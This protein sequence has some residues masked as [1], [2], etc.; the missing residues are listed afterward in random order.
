[1]PSVRADYQYGPYH[2]TKQLCYEA[3]F[4]NVEPEEENRLTEIVEKYYFEAEDKIELAMFRIGKLLVNGSVENLEEARTWGND[5]IQK[6]IKELEERDKE[7][8]AKKFE[9]LAQNSLQNQKNML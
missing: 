5:A 8:R 3:Y 6:Y 4:G 1:M 9:N 2:A 7:E